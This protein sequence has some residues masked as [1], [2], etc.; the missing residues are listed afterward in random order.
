M[1]LFYPRPSLSGQ[2]QAWSNQC[3][4]RMRISFERSLAEIRRQICRVDFALIDATEDFA[5]ASDAFFQ[6]HKALGP[7]SMAVYTDIVHEGLELLVRRLGVTLLL[8][9]MNGSEWD[10]FFEHKFPRT[11]PL[12]SAQGDSQSLAPERTSGEERTV[13]QSYPFKSIAG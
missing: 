7:K 10:N 12:S 2:L 13:K 9:P 4:G 8:G 6:I 3:G 11:I 1:V 5:Q